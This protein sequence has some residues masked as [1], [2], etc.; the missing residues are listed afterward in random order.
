MEILTWLTVVYAVVLVAVLA[1][2]LIIILTT[3]M[4]IGGKLGKIAAGLKLVETQTA[5]LNPNVEKLNEG[6]TTLAG[7]LSVVNSHFAG[8]DQHLDSVLE[9]TAVR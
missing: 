2:G 3:L 1:V 5:P 4:S 8:A 9:K 7:G 6:L